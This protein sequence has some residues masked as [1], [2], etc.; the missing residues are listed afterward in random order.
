MNFPCGVFLEP[1][2][3]EPEQREFARVQEV[4]D[5]AAIH[6][7][8]GQAV[9]MPREKADRSLTLGQLHHPIAAPI[10]DL[11]FVIPVRGEPD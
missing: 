1:E 2:R 3:G 7:V 6:R 8:P 4:D 9:R 5:S 11:F 10:L